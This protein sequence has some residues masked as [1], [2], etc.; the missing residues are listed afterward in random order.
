MSV[1]LS[2]DVQSRDKYCI[3]VYNMSAESRSGL[4]LLPMSCYAPIIQ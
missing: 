2:Q 1:S 4:L 3:V